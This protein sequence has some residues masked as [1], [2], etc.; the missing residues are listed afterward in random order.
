MKKQF[1]SPVKKEGGV[2]LIL[3]MKRHS[4]VLDD[5]LAKGR[6]AQQYP[7]SEE[8]EGGIAE[9]VACPAA[10]RPRRF[11]RMAEYEVTKMEGVDETDPEI[12]FKDSPTPSPP[13]ASQASSP[14]RKR[15]RRRGCDD[16]DGGNVGAP[17]QWIDGGKKRRLSDSPSS[18]SSGDMAED[19]ADIEVAAV[20]KKSP[21]SSSPLKTL[22]LVLGN[23]TVS[24]IKL[25]QD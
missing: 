5:V 4:P 21:A 23:E 11:I 12:S 13:P 19:E 17:P 9:E 20:A 18:S 24:T 15:K 8:V 10:K 25:Q 6:D 16:G 1:D 7:E 14:R 2:K 3:R 22:K